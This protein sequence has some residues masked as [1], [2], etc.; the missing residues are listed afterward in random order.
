A[1]IQTA[2]IDKKLYRQSA[3]FLDSAWV[4]LRFLTLISFGFKERGFQ[5]IS[6]I[7]FSKNT[8]PYHARHFIF[9]I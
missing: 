6:K 9:I 1:H 4:W 2:A 8:P 3:T 7:R 5:S